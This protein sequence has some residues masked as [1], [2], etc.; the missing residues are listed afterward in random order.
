MVSLSI[1]I[2]TYNWDCELLV[3]SLQSQCSSLGIEYEI[4][5]ADDCSPDR[6][7]ADACKNA[8][9]KLTNCSFIQLE[10][11]IGRAAIRNLLAD[12]S[13]YQKLLFLDCDAAVENDK[14][15]RRYIDK[16]PIGSHFTTI[17]YIFRFGNPPAIGR[18][19]LDNITPVN[20]YG[21]QIVVYL[22][23]IIGSITQ[24]TLVHIPEP[25][26]TNNPVIFKIGNLSVVR[27]PVTFVQQNNS[28]LTIHIN[29][30]RA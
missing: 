5:I 21:N 19:K 7:K 28:L 16:F 1:L 18:Y 10:K 22:N 17:G 11:N 3:N 4:I 29:G 2:P 8:V 26:V 20:R 25:L 13:Q 27:L 24:F 30:N 9:E 12:K 14:F 15:I 23:N 6:F